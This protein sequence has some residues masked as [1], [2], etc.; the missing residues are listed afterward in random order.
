MVDRWKMDLKTV[1]QLIAMAAGAIGLWTTL[2]NR[3]V[4]QE[5]KVQS[6]DQ[7]LQRMEDKLDRLVE[8]VVGR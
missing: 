8:K 1:L 5:T 3:V 4:A 2:N 6:L 7:R